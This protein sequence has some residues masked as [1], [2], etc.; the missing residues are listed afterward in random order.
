M[1]AD[2]RPTVNHEDLAAALI[3]EEGD[4]PICDFQADNVV[5]T[6]M[7]YYF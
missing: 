1:I 2:V 7:A 5:G 6:E 3:F 4:R